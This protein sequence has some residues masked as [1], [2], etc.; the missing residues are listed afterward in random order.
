M[1]DRDGN[2]IAGVEAEA[3]SGC[4]L[5]SPPP[6]LPAAGAGAAAAVGAGA[7]LEPA[8]GG[9][10]GA[11]VGIERFTAARSIDIP[12]SSTVGVT[13]HPSI[14]AV[15]GRSQSG[16]NGVGRGGWGGDDLQC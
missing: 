8:G 6:P 3:C 13:C 7:K 14:A 1:P 2:R 9:G 12:L 4:G 15:R 5:G 10:G 16:G 11:A